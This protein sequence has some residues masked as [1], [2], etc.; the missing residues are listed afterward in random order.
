MSKKTKNRKQSTNTKLNIQVFIRGAIAVGLLV[1][2]GAMI[3]N[4][5][6]NEQAKI[7]PTLPSLLSAVIFA[8]GNIR[9]NEDD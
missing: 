3:L 9:S 6:P 4:L 7:L 2:V 8:F 1:I 5:P